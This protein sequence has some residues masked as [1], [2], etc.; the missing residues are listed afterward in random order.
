MWEQ[1]ELGSPEALRKLLTHHI[2]LCERNCRALRVDGAICDAVTF[3]LVAL[4]D[5]TVLSIPGP[6]ADQWMASP[7]QVEYYG[8]M[9]AGERFFGDLEH[10]LR[11]PEASYEALEVFYFCLCL[12]FQG[13]YFDN[14]SER[15]QIITAL[16]KSLLRVRR[17][18]TPARQTSRP[19][20]PR[21]RM[22]SIP[23]GAYAVAAG[24]IIAIGWTLACLSTAAASRTTIRTIETTFQP[25][26]SGR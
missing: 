1:K 24:V 15:E 11:T 13:K 14:A 18:H 25:K 6:C 3:A 5:E 4:V 21:K 9:V 23:P 17:R 10:L 19:A 2:D 20:V 8:E 7:L 26:W 16:A 12:G 22:L